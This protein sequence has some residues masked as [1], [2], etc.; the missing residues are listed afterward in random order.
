MSNKPKPNKDQYNI[1]LDRINIITQDI[2]THLLQ[3][4]VCKLDKEITTKVEKGLDLL[5]DAYLIIGE[6]R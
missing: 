5:Y 3:H 6:R 2:N 4:P 1:L